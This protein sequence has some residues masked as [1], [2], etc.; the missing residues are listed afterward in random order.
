MEKPISKV[1]YSLF[2]ALKF[3]L[4]RVQKQKGQLVLKHPVE[5]SIMNRILEFIC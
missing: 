3:C 1:L 2:L 5:F 4:K